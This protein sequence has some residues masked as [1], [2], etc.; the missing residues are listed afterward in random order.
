M[1]LVLQIKT[2][3]AIKIQR[4]AK[5][6]ILL[7]NEEAFSIIK[8]KL[9]FFDSLRNELLT[10]CQIK[11]A[12]RWRRYIKKKN[13]RLAKLAED[14]EKKLAAKNKGKKGGK[15]PVKKKKATTMKAATAAAF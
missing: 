2:K 3:A 11:I 9:F 12:Y 5:K 8:T 10:D 15:L 6:T 13:A 14:K 1:R 7:T 4:L